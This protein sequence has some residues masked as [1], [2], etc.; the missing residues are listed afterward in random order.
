MVPKSAFRYRS[1]TLETITSHNQSITHALTVSG[2]L[3]PTVDDAPT[4][5]P[6]GA[7]VLAGSTVRGETLGRT[8]QL[9]L[10]AGTLFLTHPRRPYGSSLGVPTRR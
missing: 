1:I 10:V 4:P 6:A 8:C 3:L 9:L 2:A 5:T 7:V